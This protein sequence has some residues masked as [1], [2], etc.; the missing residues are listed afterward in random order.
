MQ[1]EDYQVVSTI[2]YSLAE[3]PR[4]QLICS[5]NMEVMSKGSEVYKAPLICHGGRR[6]QVIVDDIVTSGTPRFIAYG[7]VPH[8]V[9]GE[10]QIFKIVCDRSLRTL[11]CVLI[12]TDNPGDELRLS[13]AIYQ[14]WRI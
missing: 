5:L 4:A 13:G 8:N 7:R 9:A 10:C 6:L 2:L 12:R 3:D 11:E 1:I 14:G